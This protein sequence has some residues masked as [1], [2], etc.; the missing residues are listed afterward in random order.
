MGILKKLGIDEMST[1]RKEAEMEK[2]KN[3]LKQEEKKM[4]EDVK[5]EK[6]AKK[7]LN[8][9]EVTAALTLNKTKTAELKAKRAEYTNVADKKVYKE[10][11]KNFSNEKRRLCERLVSIEKEKAKKAAVVAKVD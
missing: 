9:G 5:V 3:K 2:L 6:I 4:A 7:K 11:M 8:K 1:T 10:T